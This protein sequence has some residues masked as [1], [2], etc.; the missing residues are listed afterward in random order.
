MRTLAVGFVILLM[1][2]VNWKVRGGKGRFLRGG[3]VS[4]HSAIAFFL[5]T[6]IL[7]LTQ[8]ALIGILAFLLALLVS[9][10]RV[11]AGVHTVREVVFGA[12]LGI[13]LPVILFRMLPILLSQVPGRTP[14]SGS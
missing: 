6:I 12:L 10:S 9:Q 5:G 7:L 14:G 11:E 1:L 3:V 4:G 2:L 8:H 13:L